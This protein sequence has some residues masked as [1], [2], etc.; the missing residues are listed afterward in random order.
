MLDLEE[1]LGPRD[2]QLLHSLGTSEPAV[3][4]DVTNYHLSRVGCLTTDT[5]ATRLLSA[6]VQVAFEKAIDE[7]KLIHA[8][9][10]GNLS[11]GTGR[12]DGGSA[13]LYRSGHRRHGRSEEASASTGAPSGNGEVK[14]LDLDSLCKGLQRNGTLPVGPS[15]DLLLQPLGLS[16]DTVGS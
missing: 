3:L 5:S 14:E 10:R 7:A 6:A 8:S 4:D 11:G 1:I 15:L 2:E 13:H 12:P 16:A 9:S